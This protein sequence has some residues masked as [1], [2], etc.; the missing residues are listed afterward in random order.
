MKSLIFWLVLAAIGFFIAP[1]INKNTPTRTVSVFKEADLSASSISLYCGDKYRL[2]PDLKNITLVV[3]PVKC[4]TDWYIRNTDA[5]YFELAP[6][7]EIWVQY[8]FADGTL[9]DPHV[10]GTGDGKKKEIKG[11][12]VSFRYQNGSRSSVK[13][14]VYQH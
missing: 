8:P 11:T 3:P 13:V 6:E 1:R 2:L 14:N 12:I 9:G 5:N 7:N 4:W 10:D